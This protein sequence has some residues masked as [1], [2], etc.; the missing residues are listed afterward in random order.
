LDLL[1]INA[2]NA[3]GSGSESAPGISL[4]LAGIQSFMG[5]RIKGGFKAKK[6]GFSVEDNKKK[7]Q[8]TDIGGDLRKDNIIW[9]CGWEDETG[10]SIAS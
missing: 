2:R 6:S 7:E 4:S 1:G 5:G 3:R 10:D 8:D 9:G